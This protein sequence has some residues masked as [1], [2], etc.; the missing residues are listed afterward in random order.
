MSGVL[1]GRGEAGGVTT[2]M[3]TLSKSPRESLNKKMTRT[4]AIETAAS[5]ATKSTARGVI[6]R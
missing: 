3:F 6:R 4:A 5:P 2:L 1:A